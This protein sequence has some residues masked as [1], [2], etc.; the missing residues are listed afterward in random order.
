[1]F[2]KFFGGNAQQQQSL[3]SILMWA[4]VLGGFYFML[5]RPQQKKKKQEEEMRNNVKIG[6]E[7]VTIGGL[8]GKIVNVRDDFFMIECGTEKI[9]IKKWAISGFISK[10]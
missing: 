8:V 3:M 1:M 4:V 10:E 5:F 2:E 6:D 9:K 7:I